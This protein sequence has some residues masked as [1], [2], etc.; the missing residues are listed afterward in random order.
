MHPTYGN[1]L[2]ADNLIVRIIRIIDEDTSHQGIKNIKEWIDEHKYEF[3]DT[4]GV[5]IEIEKIIEECLSR[6]Q[7]CQEVDKIKKRIPKAL[8]DEKR[9][10]T[11]PEDVVQLV[12]KYADRRHQGVNEAIR[13]LRSWCYF[14]HFDMQINSYI[15]SC[16][17]CGSRT[18]HFLLDHQQREAI[19]KRHN[20]KFILGHYGSGKTTVSRMIC[21]QELSIFD[22]RKV[23]YIVFSKN[24]RGIEIQTRFRKELRKGNHT[25]LKTL[26]R[27]ECCEYCDMD[28][29]VDNLEIIE[30][31]TEQVEDNSIVIFDECPLETK[32]KSKRKNYDWSQL[33]NKGRK[34]NISLVVCLQPIQ[35]KTTLRSKSY[36]VI[37]PE[38]SLIVNLTYQYRST[39]KILNL[40]NNLCR[41]EVPCE[42]TNVAGEAGHDVVGPE[43]TAIYIDNEKDHIKLNWLRN[44][45]DQIGVLH[46]ESELKVIYDEES[47]Y[48]AEQTFGPSS[49]LLTSLDQFQGC[50]VP[51][52]VVF[53]TQDNTHCRLIEMCSR[54]QYKLYLVIRG[55][56]LWDILTTMEEHVDIAHI[57]P[58]DSIKG[59]LCMS[60]PS[61][62]IRKIDSVGEDLPPGPSN[63]YKEIDS[64]EIND[65]KK[66]GDSSGGETK[67]H[68]S[69]AR[70][71]KP[72]QERTEVRKTYDKAKRKYVEDLTVLHRFTEVKPKEYTKMSASSQEVKL[73]DAVNTATEK[74]QAFDRARDELI[75]EIDDEKL[76]GIEDSDWYRENNIGLMTSVSK[77]ICHV[78]AK[79]FTDEDDDNTIKVLPLSRSAVKHR[80]GGKTWTDEELIGKGNFSTVYKVVEFGVTLAVKKVPN[81]RG[82]ALQEMKLLEQ[83]DHKR[84]ISYHRS[85][86]E[87]GKICSVMEYA[88]EGTLTTL[89]EKEAEQSDNI[90]FEEWNVWRLLWQ[91]S[92]ALSYLHSLPTPILH[93]DLNP[94]NIL[95]V[96]VWNDK[97]K[98]NCTRHKLGN[99]GV[100]QLLDQVGL[101]NFYS[102]TFNGGRIYHQPDIVREALRNNYSA[103]YGWEADV[104][105]LGCVLAF[106]CRRGDH[107]FQQP[108]QVVRWTGLGPDTI[109]DTYSPDLRSLL[110]KMLDPEPGERPSAAQVRA[111]YTAERGEN[112]QH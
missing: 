88:D 92:D 87:N 36:A 37:G 17:A 18:A 2:N 39:Q 51:V 33:R 7:D 9:L 69:K 80:K 16:E 71:P 76:E 49:P 31:I 99:F 95:C 10:I 60:E 3:R 43:V 82:E 47:R 59:H 12:L 108:D 30:R 91:L 56:A 77:D 1:I 14:N 89:V 34:R 27:A 90:W 5:L 13:R 40:V 38:S 78:L 61:N 72:L 83:V 103:E 111:E 73:M 66:K 67:R 97:E 101:A 57:I 65:H 45:L 46:K 104:W 53:Y 105:S 107:L 100:S 102:S 86:L 55:P 106:L 26:S 28:S 62:K 94:D 52:A 68:I 35:I 58:Q 32:I 4:N 84:I 74:W 109:P 96:N 75:D 85:Y 41:G 15:A 79:L 11:V 8:Q 81:T 48:L 19:S 70:S 110:G 42:Y 63:I 54:A 44:Q 6:C 112:V 64:M 29:D 22:K 21:E 93:R 50:E 20:F 98:S 25:E 23:F 24:S